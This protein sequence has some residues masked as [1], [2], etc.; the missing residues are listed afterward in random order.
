MEKS[1]AFGLMVIG[2]KQSQKDQ[3]TVRQGLTG[4]TMKSTV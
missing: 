2:T 1:P 3:M 4:I